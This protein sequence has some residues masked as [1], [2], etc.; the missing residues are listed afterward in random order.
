MQEVEPKY[1]GM[2][3]K[4][5]LM[6]ELVKKSG[7]SYSNSQKMVKELMDKLLK[8]CRDEDFRKNGLTLREE[9]ELVEDFLKRSNSLKADIEDI[10]YFLH[11]VNC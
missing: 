1:H 3:E 7:K 9:L 4:L 8:F 11:L 5:N 10:E 2:E 6:S